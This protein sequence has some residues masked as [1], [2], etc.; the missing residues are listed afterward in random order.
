MIETETSEPPSTSASSPSIRREKRARSS[1]RVELSDTTGLISL[2]DRALIRAHLLQCLEWLSCTGEVRIR[3]VDDSEMTALHAA[4]CND[5]ST[6]DVLT[7][8]LSDESSDSG[9]SHELDVDLV[10]CADQATRQADQRDLPVTSELLLYALHGVLHCLGYDDHNEG[11]SIAMH[12]REDEVLHA[13]GVGAVF[14]R[15]PKSL[16]PAPPNGG[17]I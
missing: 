16:N 6:T 7:F 17:S 11:D 3:I 8:D 1:M 14:A 5:P 15:T 13:I 9:V 12:A 10:L 2:A 4:H